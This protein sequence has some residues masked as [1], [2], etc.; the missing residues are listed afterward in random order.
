[1]VKKKKGGGAEDFWG[2]VSGW[3]NV[4]VN[5]DLLLGSDEYGFCGLEELDGSALG[6]QPRD[7]GRRRWRR[8]RCV[9]CSVAVASASHEIF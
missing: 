1:M 9:Q 3:K 7:W 5:D 6:T 2:G 4:A 8:R